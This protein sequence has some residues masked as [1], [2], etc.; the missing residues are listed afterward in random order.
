MMSRRYRRIF[1][2][3]NIGSRGSDIGEIDNLVS[4]S[5]HVRGEIQR[6]L[7]SKP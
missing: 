5:S 3:G 6:A 4:I 1:S 2:I 7:N